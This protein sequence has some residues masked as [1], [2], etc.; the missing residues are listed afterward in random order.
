MLIEWPVPLS[1]SLPHEARG[2]EDKKTDEETC[3]DT[4]FKRER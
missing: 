2:R 1:N 4:N 3:V